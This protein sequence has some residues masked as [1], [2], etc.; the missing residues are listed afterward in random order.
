MKSRWIRMAVSR[1]CRYA[2]P[3][4][5]LPSLVPR[6]AADPVG[7]PVALPA[8]P[9]PEAGTENPGRG[10]PD[11]ARV[12][13]ERA[14][15][16]QVPAARGSLIQSRGGPGSVQQVN[17][18]PVVHL[19]G[20]RRSRT[21][22]GARPPE[23]PERS[24]ELEE[25]DP[26]LADRRQRADLPDP[27]GVHSCASDLVSRGGEGAGPCSGSDS[28]APAAGCGGFEDPSAGGRWGDRD[29]ALW[30]G[31]LERAH[32]PSPIARGPAMQ[33]AEQSVEPE[34]PD[35][36]RVRRG[37]SGCCPSTL[38]RSACHW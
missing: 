28:I 31:R 11:P 33:S 15:Q 13:T 16:V 2:W 8:P 23:Q 1:W 5:C 10:K 6:G 38:G 4:D 36:P 17:P 14:E 24:L 12:G 30:A 3:W 37:W 26:P 7:D 27:E 32:R 25:T 18:L 35:H 34:W 9:E 20:R 19:C 21:S 29:L 22:T